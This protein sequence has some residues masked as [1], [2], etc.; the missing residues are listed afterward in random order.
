V[1]LLGGTVKNRVTAWF[2]T[3][4][5]FA[6]QIRAT[7]EFALNGPRHSKEGHPFRLR[8]LLEDIG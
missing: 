7:I 8:P 5:A 1:W 3:E 4:D 6:Q 2:V